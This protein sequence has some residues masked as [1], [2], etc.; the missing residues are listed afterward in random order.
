MIE[1]IAGPGV[2]ILLALAVKA[3]EE[4]GVKVPL[5]TCAVTPFGSPAIEIASG[6]VNCPCVTA[7]V[8]VVGEDWLPFTIMS[9]AAVAR[10]HVGPAEGVT[11]TFNVADR[12]VTPAISPTVT[13]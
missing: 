5:V 9:G 10:L 11:I 1:S 6:P 7:H 4:P 8:K 13:E 12:C 2:A 3:V